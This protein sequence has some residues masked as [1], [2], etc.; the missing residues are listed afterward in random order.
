MIVF[1]KPIDGPALQILRVY[2]RVSTHG[3]PPK[4]LRRAFNEL[5]PLNQQKAEQSM[6]RHVKALKGGTP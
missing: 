2:L 1:W 3:S 5:A 6:L 4:L